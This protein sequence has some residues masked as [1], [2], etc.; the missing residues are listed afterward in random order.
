MDKIVETAGLD[1]AALCKLLSQNPAHMAA[2][3][4]LQKDLGLP[5]L[6]LNTQLPLHHDHYSDLNLVTTT[7]AL[8]DD[9]HEDAPVYASHGCL[10][11]H[12]NS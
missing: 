6:T 4:A 8:A 9:W 7:E 3:E 11:A 12:S 10:S 2:V 1:G 5:D